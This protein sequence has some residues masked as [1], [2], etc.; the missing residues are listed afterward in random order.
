MAKPDGHILAAHKGVVSAGKADGYI[1]PDME[2]QMSF[3]HN[4]A[5]AYN[6][7]GA[8]V[9]VGIAS[10]ESKAHTDDAMVQG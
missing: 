2:V 8:A 9:G 4:L 10:F 3:E 5:A 7:L 1:D 6:R